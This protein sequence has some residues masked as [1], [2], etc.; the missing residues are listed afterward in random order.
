LG[1]SIEI[2]TGIILTEG[3]IN[4][5]FNIFPVKIYQNYF[6]QEIDAGQFYHYY[7]DCEMMMMILLLVVMLLTVVCLFQP[8]YLYHVHNE[9]GLLISDS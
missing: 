4:I 8:S 2:S 6:R 7:F 5:L 1:H 9:G 3:D